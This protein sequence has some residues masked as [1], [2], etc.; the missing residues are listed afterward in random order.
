MYLHR[1]IEPV[2]REVSE[3]Y[4]VV[5]LT[6]ARQCGKSTC[7]E[8][9]ADD[10]VR[11]RLS[12]DDEVLLEEARNSASQFLVHHPLP[13]FIDEIQRAPNLFLQIKA[14]VDA[15]N[16]Y[17]QVWASGSQKFVL[18]KGVADSLAGRLCPLELMPLSL[19]ERQGKGLEHKPAK[20]SL[21]RGGFQSFRGNL[22]SNDPNGINFQNLWHSWFFTGYFYVQRRHE[23][24]PSGKHRLVHRL[25]GRSPS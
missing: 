2:I 6:G 11:K 22:H 16:D 12:L 23:T 18:M 5:L 9:L 25:I 13:L 10:D 7:L 20:S 4:K 8:H 19:Y 1:T 24:S 3:I 14:E 21:F 17:G 15:R